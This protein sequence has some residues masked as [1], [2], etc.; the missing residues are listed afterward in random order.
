MQ[1]EKL[2]YLLKSVHGLFIRYKKRKCCKY[3]TKS[4][5]KKLLMENF[6]KAMKLLQIISTV[7]SKLW[8]CSVQAMLLTRIGSFNN[9]KI[10]YQSNYDLFNFFFYT[11]DVIISCILWILVDKIF[12][13]FISL[14]KIYQLCQNIAPG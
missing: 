4:I 3:N 13:L 6:P 12:K 9:L 7:V 1:A 11:L 2:V 14:I 5:N 10:E 8:P